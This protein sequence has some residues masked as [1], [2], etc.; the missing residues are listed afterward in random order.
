MSDFPFGAVREE[1]RI[2]CR[3]PSKPGLSRQVG[4][5]CIPPGPLGWIRDAAE[6]TKWSQVPKPGVKTHNTQAVSVKSSRPRCLC[7]ISVPQQSGEEK[8]LNGRKWQCVVLLWVA[9]TWGPRLSTSMAAL[10]SH[11]LSHSLVTGTEVL[12]T[13]KFHE[14][15]YLNTHS[16]DHTG[17]RHGWGGSFLF[18]S[19]FMW[20]CGEITMQGV[21]S[22]KA[23]LRSFLQ[24]GFFVLYLW[25]PF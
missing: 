9:N 23:V 13:D 16:K 14:L 21:D 12:D 7:H 17:K 4:A 25:V 10:T 18:R 5:S 11:S 2:S 19:F 6:L 1:K 3:V 24:H 15:Q 20:A 22:V 8:M